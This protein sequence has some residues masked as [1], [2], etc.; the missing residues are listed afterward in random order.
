MKKQIDKNYQVKYSYLPFQVIIT[1]NKTKNK[2]IIQSIENH[3][4]FDLIAAKDVI[5]S[6]NNNFLIQLP[7]FKYNLQTSFLETV[8]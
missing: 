8:G 5:T 3:S 7:P 4:L 6:H 2:G 1:D